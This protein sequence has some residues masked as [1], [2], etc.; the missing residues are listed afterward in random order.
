[1]LAEGL[2]FLLNPYYLHIPASDSS[3][4]AGW[5]F[6]W[7]CDTWQLWCS[8]HSNS[9]HPHR[10]PPISALSILLLWYPAQLSRFRDN[11]NQWNSPPRSRSL[12]QETHSC[13]GCYKAYVIK[14]IWKYSCGCVII[15]M[16]VNLNVYAKSFICALDEIVHVTIMSL[17]VQL[18]PRYH[19]HLECSINDNAA[20]DVKKIIRENLGDSFLHSVLSRHKYRT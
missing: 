1:M 18:W 2:C 19:W 13:P 7:D 20:T 3:F 4:I 17:K 8:C 9:Y 15:D 11:R 6:R 10:W 14:K 16:W 5:H 12:L